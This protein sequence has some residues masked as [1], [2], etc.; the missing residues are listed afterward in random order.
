MLC[1]EKI[2]HGY[3]KKFNFN[4]LHLELVGNYRH[5]LSWDFGY[6]KWFGLRKVK[7]ILLLLF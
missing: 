1:Y 2:Y 3:K 6:K 5:S 4:K 7:L